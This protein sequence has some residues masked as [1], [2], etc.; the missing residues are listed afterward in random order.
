MEGWGWLAGWS[1]GRLTFDTCHRKLIGRENRKF[2]TR[3]SLV[4]RT[5]K[6]L[7][8]AC[9][10]I[11]CLSS[12]KKKEEE[13]EEQ[14]ELLHQSEDTY[15]PFS[16]ESVQSTAWLE[17]LSVS[18]NGHYLSCKE[19]EQE[20]AGTRR[21]ATSITECIPLSTNRVQSSAWIEALSVSAINGPYL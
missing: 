2:T 3:E 20:K 15:I 11:P 7:M 16:N 9:C 19:E 5:T 10:K 13:Q 4:N 12:I 6:N 21:N 18:A 17:A 8:N 14:D 1:A